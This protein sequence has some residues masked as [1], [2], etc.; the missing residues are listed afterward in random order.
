M[1]ISTRLFPGSHAC[2]LL[3]GYVSQDDDWICCL[4]CACRFFGT[5]SSFSFGQR[6]VTNG[7]SGWISGNGTPIDYPY[8]PIRPE[9]KRL[10]TPG[11]EM[12]PKLH[13]SRVSPFTG[14]KRK[15]CE[16]IG[17]FCLKVIAV[18]AFNHFLVTDHFKKFQSC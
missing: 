14:R 2:Q 12:I 4:A 11:S 1:H 5:E 18:V 10:H 16:C 7:S 15:N 8:L 17:L 6:H 3:R 9:I 13:A